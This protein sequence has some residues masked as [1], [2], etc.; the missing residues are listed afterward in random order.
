VVGILILA[1]MLPFMIYFMNMPKEGA[2]PVFWYVMGST[3][4]LLFAVV[5]LVVTSK[6]S[7]TIDGKSITYLYRPFMRRSKSIHWD[8]I[9]SYEV[10]KYSAVSEFGGYGYRKLPKADTVCLNVTGNQCLDMKLENGKRL[11]LG[12][13]KSEEL[14]RVLNSISDNLG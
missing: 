10:R 4:L 5:A 11:I 6:L 2:D 1:A 12:T 7:I 13:Q 3:T 14:K 9:Q 8:E